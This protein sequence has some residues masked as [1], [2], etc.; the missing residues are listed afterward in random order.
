[1]GY[2]ANYRF[3]AEKAAEVLE[4]AGITETPVNLSLILERY[5]NEIR[6]V[7]YSGFMRASVRS[8]GDVISFFNSDMGGLCLR[9]FDEPFYYLL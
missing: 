8:I 3:A 4:D 6:S 2:S 1:M 5:S 7:T 9:A